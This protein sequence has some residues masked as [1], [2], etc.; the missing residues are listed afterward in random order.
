MLTTRESSLMG[1][2]A[3]VTASWYCWSVTES[4]SLLKM[5]SKFDVATDADWFALSSSFMGGELSDEGALGRDELADAVADHR[6]VQTDADELDVECVAVAVLL[7]AE[8]C[9]GLLEGLEGAGFAGGA[10]LH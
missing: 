7:V 1:A 4:V 2:R 6:V 9:L 10:P 8:H 5:R 3:A